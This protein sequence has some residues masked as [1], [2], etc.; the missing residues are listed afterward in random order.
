MCKYNKSLW[1]FLVNRYEMMD[2]SWIFANFVA[3]RTSCICRPR[4]RRG[5]VTV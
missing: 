3:E 1:F 5:F 2:S 4:R